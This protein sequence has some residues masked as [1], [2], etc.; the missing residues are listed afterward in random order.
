MWLWFFLEFWCRY[1]SFENASLTPQ[2]THTHAHSLPKSIPAPVLSPPVPPALSHGKAIT[3]YFSI[4]LLSSLISSG[5]RGTISC[6]IPSTQGS[7]GSEWYIWRTLDNVKAGME[8]Q[9]QRGESTGPT[10]HS[11][12]MVKAQLTQVSSLVW[13]SLCPYWGHTNANQF[14]LLQKPQDWHTL[15]NFQRGEGKATFCLDSLSKHSISWM[16]MGSMCFSV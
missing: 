9:T 16:K 8:Y 4:P 10:S 11:M 15:S 5:Q 13:G 12:S 14:P 6:C 7:A 2:H 3:Y 1:S